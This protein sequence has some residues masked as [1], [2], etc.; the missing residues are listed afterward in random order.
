MSAA[1]REASSTSFGPE[2]WQ[3]YE[4]MTRE[5]FDDLKAKG[6]VP[7]WLGDYDWVMAEVS[8][9]RREMTQAREGV[10]GIR[11]TFPSPPGTVEVEQELQRLAKEQNVREFGDGR[12]TPEKAQRFIEILAESP[13]VVL[14]SIDDVDEERCLTIADLRKLLAEC[15]AEYDDRAVVVRVGT[16]DEGLH[17]G[18]LRRVTVDYGC[19]DTPV[20]MLDANQAPSSNFPDEDTE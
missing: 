19:T 18:D 6:S 14:T 2:S 17:L 5:Q 3:F 16:R 1:A 8:R 15:P 4:G 7:I 11:I 12:L 9:N 20:L 10:S 13:T